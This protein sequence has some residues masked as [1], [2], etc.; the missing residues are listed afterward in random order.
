MPR[1]VVRIGRK[2]TAETTHG[3]DGIDDSLNWTERLRLAWRALRGGAPESWARRGVTGWTRPADTLTGMDALISDETILAQQLRHARRKRDDF[4]H[5]LERTA[6]E[7]DWRAADLEM[8]AAVVDDEQRTSEL[9][10]LANS[11]EGRAES[12]R[13]YVEMKA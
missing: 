13:H 7:F 4:E 12:I 10:S 5:E 3:D 8:V 9:E 11:L 1:L 2:M 6:D